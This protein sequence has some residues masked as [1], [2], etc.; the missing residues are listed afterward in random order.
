MHNYLI[1]EVVKPSKNRVGT[2]FPEPHCTSGRGAG[3]VTNGIQLSWGRIVEGCGRQ[4]VGMSGTEP[5]FA[6]LRQ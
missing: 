4:E 3:G 1:E 5:K 2:G 6:R